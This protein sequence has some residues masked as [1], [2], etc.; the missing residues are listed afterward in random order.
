MKIINSTVSKPVY[1]YPFPQPQD[2]I[3]FFDIETTGLSP[4]ASSLYLIGLMRF[5]PNQNQ[6]ML[7]QWFADNYQSEKKMIQNFLEALADVEFLYHFNGQTFDIPYL[8]KKCGRHA[9]TPSAHC[10]KLLQ[11]KSGTYSIDLLKKIRPLRHALSLEKCK[12]TECERFLHLERTDSFS[13]ADLI[14]VYSE[15]MQQKILAPDNAEK[16]EQVLLL[17]NH[18]DIE[19]MLNLCSLLTYDEYLS[20]TETGCLFP[21]ETQKTLKAEQTSTEQLTITF[22]LPAA[23]PK[24]ITMYACYPHN[25]IAETEENKTDC[26]LPKASLTFQK[27]A[28]IL[29]IPLYHGTLKFFFP[30]YKNYYYLPAEDTAIHKSV[31]AFVDHA[32]RKKATAATCYTKKEGTF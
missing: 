29:K 27:K 2:K 11:D 32:Y 15:Y 6:W 5:D 14:P 24:E 30:D 23:V 18:N 12:Q 19:M 9:I 25:D 10:N 28:A 4:N 31:S 8:L 1:S 16:L 21:E 26:L 3:A 13:G 22:P 17:H 7:C 20:D